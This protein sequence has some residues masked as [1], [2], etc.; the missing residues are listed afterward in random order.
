[1]VVTAMDYQLITEKLYKLGLDSILRRCVLDQERQDTLWEFHS[2]VV[3]GHVGGKTTAQKFLQD[4]LWWATLF[5][6]AKAYARS[7][8]VCQILHKPS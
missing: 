7:C 3:G 8:D 5:K 6:D 1:M 2:G 4:G